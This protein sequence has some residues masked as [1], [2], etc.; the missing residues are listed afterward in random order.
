[1]TDQVAEKYK[2]LLAGSSLVKDPGFSQFLS[3]GFTFPQDALSSFVS[4]YETPAGAKVADRHEEQDDGD[5]A[6]SLLDATERALKKADCNEVRLGLTGG[7]D[8]RTIFAALRHLL[9]QE[10]IH[11]FTFGAEGLYDFE[12]FKRFG[13]FAKPHH[14]IDMADIDWSIQWEVRA[15]ERA[16]QPRTYSAKSYLNRTLDAMGLPK[17]HVHGFMGDAVLGGSRPGGN[18]PFA[19]WTDATARFLN[20]NDR[21][22]LQFLLGADDLDRILPEPPE[23]LPAGM[24]FYDVLD[25]G[26]RQQQRIGKNMTQKP[27]MLTPLADR[28]WTGAQLAEPDLLKREQ[29]YMRFLAEFAPDVFPELAEPDIST[30]KEHK[31]FRTAF[32]QE[33]YRDPLHT[34]AKK[35]GRPGP[36][37][38]LTTPN[39][40]VRAGRQFCER[41]EFDNNPSFN[42]F[43]REL[44][45]TFRDRNI[46]PGTLLNA[47]WDGFIERRLVDADRVKG[48][49]SL[50]INIRAGKFGATDTSG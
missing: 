30:V 6:K 32:L 17:H 37:L 15:A 38:P 35:M 8:S 3:L 46:L 27:H 29:R 14:F 50:E 28:K 16:A 4:G 10:K 41:A 12:F 19:N 33:V 47:I 11:C 25:F 48:L 2:G 31:A 21:W 39:G 43:V 23:A 18:T 5:L 34:A 40:T 9:P 20:K 49:I 13:G 24:D 45:F 26:L 22:R 1:M 36:S 7:L 42:A 44:F